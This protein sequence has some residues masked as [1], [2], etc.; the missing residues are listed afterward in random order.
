MTATRQEHSW[1]SWVAFAAMAIGMFFAILDIQIVASSLIDIQFALNIPPDRLSYL[2][3]TYLIAEIVAIA[4]TGWLTRVLS[5]RW[6]FVCAMIGFVLFSV[7]CAAAPTYQW[8]FTFRAL[9]GFFGGAIIPVIFTAAFRMFPPADQGKATVLGGGLA[10]LAPTVGPFIGGWITETL[11]WHWLFLINIG[12]GLLVAAIAARLINIDKPDLKHAFTLDAVALASITVCLAT[13]ELT[14]KEAPSLGWTSRPAAFLAFA[15]VLTG[16]WF[17]RRSLY[18][19]APLIDLSVFGDRTFVIGCVF[20]FVL[21]MALYGMTYL[22]PL[23]LG[24]VRQHGPLTIG[25]IMMVTG[26]AQLLA[27]PAAAALEQRMDARVMMALGYGLFAAGLIWNGFATYQWDFDELFWP[28]VLRGAAVMI[29]LLPATRLALGQLPADKIANG[30]SVFNLMRN[31][32][33][34]VGLAVIDTVL[35]LRPAHHVDR[36]VAALLD[37]DR[38]MALFVGLP[39]ERF[40]GMPLEEID[41]A[42]RQVVEPLVERAAAVASFNEAWWL[43]GGLVGLALL[44]LPLMRKPAAD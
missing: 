21:G 7:C 43:V 26:A 41:A 34:A 12:P 30:S 20:S 18:R 25:T 44:A 42:T 6:L 17:V 38:D 8:L 2:Q 22:M 33:G 14:L 37:G 1:R 23:F 28:Q 32:G 13:L 19:R 15:C 36:I 27:A 40:T 24:V 11:S 29:C 9:Q 4:M 35:E 31:I 10:M 5:T 3:T 16:G 39:P